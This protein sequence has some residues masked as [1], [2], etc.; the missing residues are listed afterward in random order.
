MLKY[1]TPP[2]HTHT[3]KLSLPI[4]KHKST[5]PSTGHP[6]HITSLLRLS[7]SVLC[8]RFPSPRR[9]RRERRIK[10]ARQ[11]IGRNCIK[12]PRRDELGPCYLPFLLRQSLFPGQVCGDEEEVCLS[13]SLPSLSVCLLPFRLSVYKLRPRVVG[14]CLM[15]L[16]SC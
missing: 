11:D 10:L 3:C 9:I 16:C 14:K 13:R 15:L 5:K 4:Y 7:A 1:I 8:S 6:A 2:S 12:Q